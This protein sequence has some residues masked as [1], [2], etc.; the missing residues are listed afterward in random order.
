M[1]AGK[2]K[3][4]SQAFVGAG[5]GPLIAPFVR[6]LLRRGP[7]G[8]FHPGSP[9]KFADQPKDYAPKAKSAHKRAMSAPNAPPL[10][11]QTP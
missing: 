9:P 7:P 4:E 11:D 2:V 6:S 3:G 1:Q 10:A 8:P 5:F